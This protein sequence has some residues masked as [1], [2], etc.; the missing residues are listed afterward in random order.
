M[1]AVIVAAG[2]SSRMWPLTKEKPKCTLDLG[3][4]SLIQRS[5]DVLCAHGIKDIYVV[6][7]AMKEQI[8]NQLSDQ[9]K[10]I[11]NPFF[12]T[13]NNM[14]SLRYAKPYVLGRDFLY[15]HADLLYH[16]QIITRCIEFAESTALLVDKLDCSEE[17]MK[18][19]VENGLLVESDKKIPKDKAYGE[20]LGIG[21]FSGAISFKLFDE[22]D[23]ALGDRRHI[24][25][26]DTLA[27]T[28]MAQKGVK[29]PVLDVDGLPWIEIDFVEDLETARA[30]ILPAIE[31]AFDY[32][33]KYGTSKCQ[34]T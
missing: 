20:W 6:V 14:V 5:V 30:E 31:A 3:G 12:A 23:C 33:H 17:E 2:M 1:D 22:I 11:F 29:L 28:K 10:Y 15:L 9:V 18:V 8:I 27:F 7:G 13:T 32:N 26:Y 16:P 4:K 19:V 24:M 25:A 21:K 34:I